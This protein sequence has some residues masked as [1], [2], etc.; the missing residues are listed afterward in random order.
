[1]A[2]FA[3][4]LLLGALVSLSCS[5]DARPPAPDAQ[6]TP[7]AQVH[8]DAAPTADASL[9]D[10]SLPDAAPDTGVDASP[11]ASAP[12]LRDDG[13]APGSWSAQVA[14]A[15]DPDALGAAFTAA[16]YVP[17]AGAYAM[18]ARVLPG[19]GQPAFR[20]Y[21]LGDTGFEYSPGDY[22]PAST[23]KLTAAVGALHF[24]HGLGLTGAAQ[25]SFTDNDGTYNGTVENI[26]DL[27]LSIS[28]NVSYNR[29][30][31]IAGFDALNDQVLVE[32]NGL[33][34][35]VIQ[36]RYT[37]G[38]DLRTS[39]AITWSEGSLNG[40]IPQRVGTGQHPECP[41]E[42]NC[43]TLYELL[44][45]MRRVTLHDEI[46]ATHR[47][48]LASADVA[49]LHQALLDATTWLADGATAALG[50][51]VTVYNK[52]GYVPD[53][54]RLDHGLV[55]DD[56]TGDR[57]LIALSLPEATTS[58]A[59]LSEL[60]EQVLAV[61]LADASP[62]PALQL[63]AGV[64]LPVQVDGLGG[65]T[66]RIQVDAP[67]ADEVQIWADWWHLPAVDPPAT[68]GTPFHR[69]EY[70]FSVVGRRQLVVLALQNGQ[71][72]GVRVLDVDLP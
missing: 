27:A 42:G 18:A 22:W 2:R 58:E 33:P 25:V 59:D 1:M 17:P 20:F 39:P 12:T 66:Y 43:V 14:A 24:L 45:V 28:D 48:P 55:V 26:Y 44:E 11:D 6:T 3:F 62:A 71:P 40:V 4:A 56:V 41:N 8:M 38:D 32:A 46:P 72:I 63:T 30:V 34:Q 37:T 31:E 15:T 57:Y 70:T 54:D 7:D 68:N 50:H 29:L 69:L 53:N 67:G 65:Q 16:G 49:G 9:P 47:F 64:A 36:R 21:S 13:L 5:G 10:A 23:V 35:M 61:L 19:V 52:P 60:A 51:P